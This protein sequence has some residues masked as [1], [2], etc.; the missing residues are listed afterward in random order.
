MR[1]VRMQSITNGGIMCYRK[2]D[3]AM[4]PYGTV[5][6]Y[7]HTLYCKDKGKVTIDGL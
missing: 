1:Y 3:R 7:D 4:R 2:D 6:G 5:P